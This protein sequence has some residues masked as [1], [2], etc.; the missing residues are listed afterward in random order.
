MPWRLLPGSSFLGASGP[1]AAMAVP[2][3]RVGMSLLSAHHMCPE[4]WAGHRHS[5][6]DAH[7]ELSEAVTL[8]GPWAV[9]PPGCCGCSVMTL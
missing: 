3:A 6:P 2:A 5:T 4:L 1:Q 8:L 7:L 9:G